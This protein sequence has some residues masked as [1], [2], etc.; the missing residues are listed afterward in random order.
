MNTQN[1]PPMT[2]EQS[3]Q[4]KTQQTPPGQSNDGRTQQTSAEAEMYFSLKGNI[5]KGGRYADNLSDM[6]L[7]FA[8]GSKTDVFTAR[9]HIIGGFE[10][11]FGMSPLD[12][13]DKVYGK[14][15]EIKERSQSRSSGRGR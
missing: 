8:S 13:S 10:K 11:Q 14:R 3:N 15:Q 9:E 7:G 2:P 1:T 12:Y 5:D 4:S 6:A